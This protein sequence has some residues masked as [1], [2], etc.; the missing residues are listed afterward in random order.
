MPNKYE[1]MTGK[2][3]RRVVSF[4]HPFSFGDFCSG[5]RKEIKY[6]RSNHAEEN[7]RLAEYIILEL[8]RCGVTDAEMKSWGWV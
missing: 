5:I 6:S 1:R 2:P 7:R 3:Y 8:H 4:N